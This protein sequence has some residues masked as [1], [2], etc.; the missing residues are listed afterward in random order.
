VAYL[1]AV[2]HL[3]RKQPR[4][5]GRERFVFVCLAN[6]KEVW[7]KDLESDADV[8]PE[9]EIV[10]CT[11]DISAL[12]PVH[13]RK[14]LRFNLA[15]VVHLFG[16]HDDL[17]GDIALVLVIET[18]DHLTERTCPKRRQ[19]LESVRKVVPDNQV[20]VVLVIVEPVIQIRQIVRSDLAVVFANEVDLWKAHDLFLFVF[21]QERA[22]VAAPVRA[23][24]E[25][26][27]QQD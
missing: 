9:D 16:V 14:D 22:I 8:A 13:D 21:G 25:G 3:Q 24:S 27:G 5:T 18:S 6:L 7:A 15:L 20:R 2:Q 17:A 12:R 23:T 26:S 11:N 4:R 1:K 10:E 19:D